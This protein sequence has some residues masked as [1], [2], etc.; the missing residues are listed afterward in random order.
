[1]SRLTREEIAA[2]VA[3]LHRITHFADAPIELRA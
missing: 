3:E 1:V 2:R